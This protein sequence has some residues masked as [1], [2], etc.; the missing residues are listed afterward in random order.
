MNV[1]LKPDATA[2]RVHAGTG[3]ITLSRRV[4]D[5]RSLGGGRSAGR[6]AYHC[7]SG[8]KASVQIR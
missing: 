5:R 6:P 1:R 3:D 4:A 7:S 2:H 8:F